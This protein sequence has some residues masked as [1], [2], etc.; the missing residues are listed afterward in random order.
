MGALQ[1]SDD[2]GLQPGTA[3]HG[4]QQLGRGR[5][6]VGPRHADGSQLPAWL[7]VHGGGERAEPA[8]RVVD[9]K[10]PDR[11]LERIE[12]VVGEDGDGTC[13]DG[14]WSEV[15]AV[16]VVAAKAGIQRTRL[17]AS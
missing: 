5:L 1:C 14:G 8:P 4:S 12:F 13:R 15:V 6:A 7:A 3:P 2:A 9:D 16:E 17:D 10:L 11:H